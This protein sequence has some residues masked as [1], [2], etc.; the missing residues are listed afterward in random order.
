VSLSRGEA[1]A[2]PKNGA[3]RTVHARMAMTKAV[4]GIVRHVRQA[5]SL[6]SQ[7]KASGFKTQDISVLFPNTEGSRD[8]AHEHSTK[9]PEGA[10]AGVSMGG[11]VGG[12]VGLLAG[13]GALAVPPLGLFIAAGPVMAALSGAAAGATCCGIVGALVGFG[14]PEME[15]KLYEGKIRDGNLLLAV[16][17]RDPEMRARADTIFKSNGA[18]DVSTM[19]EAHVPRHMN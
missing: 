14:I 13:L 5:E 16:H 3:A 6:V 8:F 7:L 11:L 10:I 15:A 2:S 4:I 1:L 9:A 12:A 19:R 18:H 17:T